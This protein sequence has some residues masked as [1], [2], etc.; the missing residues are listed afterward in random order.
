MCGSITH[1]NRRYL[2]A[3]QSA[4]GTTQTAFTNA[5]AVVDRIGQIKVP[6]GDVNAGVLKGN[7]LGANLGTASAAA[8]RLGRYAQAEALARRWLAVPASPV[9]EDDPQIKDS[10]AR[11]I[12]AHAIAMQGR[13]DEAQKTLQPALAYYEGEQKAGA[14]GTIF[15]RD[16]AYALYV[17]AIASSTDAA[18]RVQRDAA[19]TEAATLIAGA[20]TEARQLADMRYVAGLIAAARNTPHA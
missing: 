15:R 19:L 5:T 11:A 17:S 4:E 16:F 7:I 14:H 12:L 1:P 10:S 6:A 3:L 8:V 2:A 20:S 9:S 18:G 13:N